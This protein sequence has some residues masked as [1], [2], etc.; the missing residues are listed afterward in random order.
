MISMDKGGDLNYLVTQ[1][2]QELLE[3]KGESYSTYNEII[4]ALEC[5]KLELYRRKI[6][7][8]EDK[9]IAENGDVWL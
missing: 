2:C 4:G 1:L 9:K 8:Y 7:G 3:V 6:A 5:A